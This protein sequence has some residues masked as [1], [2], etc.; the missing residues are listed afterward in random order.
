MNGDANVAACETAASRG[1]AKFVLISAS[2]M[3]AESLDFG[4]KLPVLG[5]YINAKHR[6]EQS[7]LENFGKGAPKPGRSR[8]DN[9]TESTA[10]DHQAGDAASTEVLQND[11]FALIRPG[12]IFGTKGGIPLHVVGIPM[13]LIF[14]T[15]QL[16]RI[17]GLGP[18]FFEVRWSWV[19]VVVV[20]LFVRSFVC[21]VTFLI[22]KIAFLCFLLLLALCLL[23]AQCTVVLQPPVAVSEVAKAAVAACEQPNIS[24]PIKTEQIQSLARAVNH[25]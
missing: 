11:A 10:G 12:F 18:I 13:R 9:G 4:R 24:G 23:P 17:P 16:N 20:L 8:S 25:S 21:F 7:A 6:A 22:G 5:A 15:L 2:P 3:N 19:V 1:A 14:S